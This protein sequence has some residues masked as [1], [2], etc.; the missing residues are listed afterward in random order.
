M[1][2]SVTV[3][4]DD[5]VCAGHFPGAPVVPGVFMLG[6]CSRAGNAG[7]DARL[8]ALRAIHRM[9]FTQPA[10]PPCEIATT[11]TDIIEVPAGARI[12]FSITV[13]GQRAGTVDAE[14]EVG[15]V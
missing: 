8:G 7:P 15:S 11:A 10:V 4:V 9:R 3:G 12:K 1:T 2:A 13:D 14:W 5:P 6:L